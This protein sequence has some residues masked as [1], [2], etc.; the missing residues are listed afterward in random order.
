[1]MSFNVMAAVYIVSFIGLAW[2]MY[3]IPSNWTVGTELL[4][5][6]LGAVC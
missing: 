3:L 2:K 5:H 6:T 4:R 1:M